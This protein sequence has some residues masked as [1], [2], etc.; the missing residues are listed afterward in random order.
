[1]NSRSG[2]Q[3]EIWG[4]LKAQLVVQMDATC[5]RNVVSP[6]TSLPRFVKTYSIWLGTLHH[7]TVSVHNVTEDYTEDYTEDR[8]K[9]KIMC[10]HKIEFST[11]PS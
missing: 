8:K 11:T 6:A 9:E 3:S 10:A 7:Y 1:M 5:R 4:F 2:K